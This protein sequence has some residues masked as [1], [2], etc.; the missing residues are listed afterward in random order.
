MAEQRNIVILGGSAS[1]LMATHNI[2]KH[3]LPALKAK[4]GAKYHIYLV[5]PSSNFYFRNASPRPAAS[6]SRMAV[7][8]ITFDISE[9]FKKYSSDDFTFIEAAATGLDTTARTVTYRRS[10]ASDLEYLPYHALVVATGSRTYY[11]AFSQSGTSQEVIDAI[12]IT[13]EKVASAKDIVVVGGGPTAIEFIAEVAEHRNG[14][15]GWFFKPERKLKITL[16]TSA[17]RLLPT[18]RPAISK[19]AEQKLKALGVDIVYNTRI[20]EAKEGKDGRTVITTAKGDILETDLYVPAYGVE[21]NSSWIPADLLDEKKYLKTSDTLR[22]EGA[23]SRVYA[24]GDIG[25]YSRN[26]AWDVLS[27]LPVLAVNMKRDLVSFNPMLPTE[28]PKGKDRIFKADT[29]ESMAV[30]IGTSGGVG[31]IMGW[32]LPSLMVYFLKGRDFMVGMAGVPTIT[33]SNVKEV[34]WTK[35]EAAI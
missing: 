35:E 3:L 29:R 11:P 31:A 27:G 7:E 32:R 1:G 13:N 18:L 20:T 5:N 22:V 33:G 30:P 25:S 10:K 17:D 21:P 19:T 9:G 12:K 6:T 4:G 2:L 28:K 8:K 26:N 14:K 23:G 16:Y 34:V 15:P 24:L